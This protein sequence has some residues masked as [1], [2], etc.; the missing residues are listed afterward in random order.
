MPTINKPKPKPSARKI[1]RQSLYNN[2]QWRE[3]SKW[4]KMCHPICEYCDQQGQLTP[5]EHVHHILSPFEQGLSYEE[6]MVRLL[7]PDNLMAVCQKCHNILH[8]N[9]KKVDDELKK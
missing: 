5:A 6:K 9:V 7:D 8:G 3:L 1:E 2:K 4:Y